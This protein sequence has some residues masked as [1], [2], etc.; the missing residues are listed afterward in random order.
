MSIRLTTH[1]PL[2]TAGRLCTAGLLLALLA[3]NAGAGPAADRLPERIMFSSESSATPADNAAFA[4]GVDAL[5]AV[6]FNGT[7]RLAPTAMRTLPALSRPV[8]DGRDA[9]LF[10]GVSLG[11]VTLGDT[12]VPLQRGEMV[13]DTAAG[14]APSYWRVIPQFGRVWREKSDGDWSRAAFPLML[15]NDTENHA[16]QGLATFLY[17]DGKISSVRVQFVQQTAPY[18][19]SPHCVLWG[20]IPAT[21]SSIDPV[22]IANEQAVATAELAA[23][24]PSRPLAD[25]RARLPTGTLDG[26]GG[27]VLP[28]WQV[29]VGLVHDG[30]LYYEASPTPY[31]GYPYPLEMRFGV[32]S[33]MKAVAPPLAL[34]R[35]AEVYGPYVL[36]L[37]IGDYVPGLD[38]KWSRIRF[39]DAANMATGFGGTGT[40]KTHPNDEGDGYLEANYDAWYTAHSQADKLAQINANLRPYPWEPGTV[41]RYR[42][43]DHYMLGIAVDRFLKS[44]R[45]PDADAWEMLQKE[46]FQ[47]IG[48]AHAPA[49]RTREPGD[50]DGPV[51]FNA[52]YYPTLDDLAKIA[53]LFEDEGRH[54]DKQLL[55]REL[56]RE[57]L[58][59]HGAIDKKGD[60][61]V[62]AAGLRADMPPANLYKMGFHFTPYVGSR[63]HELHYLPTMSGFGD[64]EVILFPGRTV[65]IRA[66]K[67]AEVPQDEKARS[68]DAEAT[69][70]AI[71]RLAPF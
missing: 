56:T 22:R 19:L 55:H 21:V 46:V 66:A 36:N 53:L 15:V 16:H 7:L 37:R 27:P 50:R 57:L 3:G 6:P 59:A 26:L 70:R 40:L 20:S 61:S 13:R 28:K 63:S 18:L 17:K 64:N 69:V 65:A 23:R 49:V 71:D 47:P 60:G 14:S 51:W 29:A 39:I 45:G 4:P 52:G 48:I 8:L 44:V 42:D 68:D 30:T 5:P 67:V 24:L 2:S 43:Q 32:R 58:A 54:G 41:M 9:R 10:P 12:L 33:V 34:L 35:L 38:P 25:L 62:T 1:C 11:F 31:G